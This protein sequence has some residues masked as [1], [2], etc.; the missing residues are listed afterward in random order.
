M[1]AL[2]AFDAAA[3][4]SSFNRAAEELG[5]QQPSVSRYIAELEHEIGVR[6]FERGHR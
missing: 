1:R 2:R 5:T 4:H 3:R 6:L